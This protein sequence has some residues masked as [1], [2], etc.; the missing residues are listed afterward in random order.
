MLLFSNTFFV[1]LSQKHSHVEV[2]YQFNIK[3]DLS[4]KRLIKPGTHIISAFASS[5]QY[6]LIIKDP[7]ILL[8]SEITRGFTFKKPYFNT[9]DALYVNYQYTLPK[10]FFL[11]GAFKYLKYWTYFETNDWI[12]DFYDHLSGFSTL[13]F[14]LGGGFRFVGQNNLRFFDL[15]AGLSFGITDNPI[16][17][18][19]YL[20]NSVTYQDGNGNQGTL[21]YSWQY[22]FISRYSLGFYLGLSKDIRV[23]KNLY[24]TARYHYQFGKNSEL[25]EHTINF[26][27]Q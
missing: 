24:V 12:I 4:H 16:G 19:Q 27:H 6:P 20:S 2:D 5:N 7:S 8:Y 10:N 23:T 22:Q 9:V 13:S 18:G 3:M 11:E 14:S 26:G 15:H 21:N 17:N 25:T 1:G